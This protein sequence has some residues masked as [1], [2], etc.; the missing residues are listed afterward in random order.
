MQQSN[1]GQIILFI[2]GILLGLAMVIP[3]V[4]FALIA[5]V[6][7]LYSDILTS[8]SELKTNS[9]KSFVFL[10]PIG[11]GVIIGFII[12]L[13]ALKFLINKYLFIMICFFLGI[14]VS[15]ALNFN[16][17]GKKEPLKK[18]NYC[19]Y[20]G[21]LIPLVFTTISFIMHIDNSN[22]L[23]NITFINVL[24]LLLIGFLV[25]ASQIIPG[26]SATVFLMLFGVL[27][28]ILNTLDVKLLFNNPII[29]FNLGLI[30]IGALIGIFVF[31][32]IMKSFIKTNPRNAYYLLFGFM[33]SSL[34]SMFYNIEMFNYF[35]LTWNNTNTIVIDILLGIILF[36][37]SFSICVMI[38]KRIK[39]TLQN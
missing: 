20:I 24:L 15:Q 31:S 1:K 29:I 4:S 30:F 21:L 19:F 2:K 35:N 28:A 33:I 7:K 25:G 34:I 32:K 37:S 14:T 5:I 12:G 3:G 22:V 26:L 6:L 13:L 17:D 36:I 18:G 39:K 8:I 38:N 16:L 27:E 10:L 9:K 23:N 11:L